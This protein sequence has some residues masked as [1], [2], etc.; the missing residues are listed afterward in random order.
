MRQLAAEK[1]KHCYP[2]L[3][4]GAASEALTAAEYR[5]SRNRLALANAK[6][7][8]LQVTIYRLTKMTGT[9]LATLLQ[10][11]PQAAPMLPFHIPGGGG[12]PS[13]PSLPHP[14]PSPLYISPSLPS[15][16]PVSVGR[17]LTLLSLCSSG[18]G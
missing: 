2:R 7:M 5:W 10:R 13:P 12:S 11:V 3:Q 17:P 14:S 4:N 6:G 9:T 1:V 8:A 15:P 18:L 16:S